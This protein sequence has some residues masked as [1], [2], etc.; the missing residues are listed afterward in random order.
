M[1]CIHFRGIYQ[2]HFIENTIYL[3]DNS[4]EAINANFSIYNKYTR[5]LEKDYGEQASALR[6]AHSLHVLQAVISI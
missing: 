5:I 1:A 3:S 4:W 2:G 6:V